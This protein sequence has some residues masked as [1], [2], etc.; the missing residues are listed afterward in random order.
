MRKGRNEKPGFAIAM[1]YQLTEDDMRKL[2]PGTRVITYPELR[3]FSRIEDALD[4]HGSLVL[5][6]LTTGLSQGH[7]IALDADTERG[8]IEFFDSYG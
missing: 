5:L 1:E 4:S 6:F 8:T 7:W 2:L 3:S